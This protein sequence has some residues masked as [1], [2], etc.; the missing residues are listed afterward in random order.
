MDHGACCSQGTA[1]CMSDYRCS[2]GLEIG[3]IDHFNTQFKTT[4]NYSAIAD[5]HTLQI[6]AA[7]AQV[8]WV[9]CV[10]TSSSLVKA[11][12][13]GDSSAFA[14]ISLST[15]SQLHQLSLLFTDSLTTLWRTSKPTLVITS[16]HG[17]LHCC[18]PIISSVCLWRCYSVTAAYTCSTC[19][20]TVCFKVVTQ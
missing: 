9:C 10:F 2:F 12:N 3:F 1:T 19:S 5:L 11:S 20:F 14:L 8:F 18:T 17:H 6:T 15:G 4:L 7:Y 13:S 16:W